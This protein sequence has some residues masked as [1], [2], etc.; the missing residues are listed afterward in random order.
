MLQCDIFVGE[1]CLLAKQL[2]NE[3]NHILFTG[4]CEKIPMVENIY[5]KHF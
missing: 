3:K 1:T 2:N 4:V 5:L